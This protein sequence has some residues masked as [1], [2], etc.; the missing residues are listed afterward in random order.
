M[1][2]LLYLYKRHRKSNTQRHNKQM[3]RFISTLAALAVASGAATVPGLAKYVTVCDP[4]VQS[5][6]AAFFEAA[7][8]RSCAQASTDMRRFSLRWHPDRRPDG[9]TSEESDRYFKCANSAHQRMMRPCKKIQK[10]RNDERSSQSRRGHDDLHDD[11]CFFLKLVSLVTVVFAKG[12]VLSVAYNIYSHGLCFYISQ[13]TTAF[14]VEPVALQEPLW[15][16]DV[17]AQHKALHERTQEHG[18]HR[19][20]GI[21]RHGSRMVLQRRV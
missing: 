12:G 8:D 4:E 19:E 10:H 5:R 20:M 2:I 21:Y 11:L 9:L 7:L 14:A 16:I 17:A 13:Y 18:Q 15:D 3:M 1:F 6:P